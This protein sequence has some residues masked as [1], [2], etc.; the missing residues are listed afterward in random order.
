MI[1]HTIDYQ[2]F[3]SFE[4][5]WFTKGALPVRWM[6]AHRSLGYG[7]TIFEE[8]T[9]RYLRFRTTDDLGV[10]IRDGRLE[11]KQRL[12]AP[13][14]R[15]LPIHSPPV[16]ERWMKYSWESP[17]VGQLHFSR[18]AWRDVFKRRRLVTLAPE[19]N[20]NYQLLPQSDRAGIQIELTELTDVDKAAWWTIGFECGTCLAF[21]ALYFLEQVRFFL[22]FFP[23]AELNDSV[24]TGYPGWLRMTD[25]FEAIENFAP[26]TV[27]PETAA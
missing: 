21:T 24:I 13:N 18:S 22:R 5:R 15:T 3:E 20:G 1:L 2:S 7:G 26:K 10:K 17:A 8:R 23:L 27:S 4:I 12:T 14:V 9:D 16:P 11:I 25:S 6:D 19:H